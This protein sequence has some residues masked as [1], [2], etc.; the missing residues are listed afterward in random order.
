[1]SGWSARG[2]GT[3]RW[4]TCASSSPRPRKPARPTTAAAS[5]S[6]PTARWRCR[7]GTGSTGARTRRTP[8]TRWAR[9][10]A[11]TATARPARQSPRR[12][13]GRGARDLYA[14]ASQRAG[15]RG[16]SG[17]RRAPRR[18]AWAA[19]RRRVEPAEARRQLRLAA[20]VGRARLQFRARH[21]LRLAAGF[22][23]PLLEWTPS[24]A[25]S[26]LAVY[27]GA[28]FPQWRGAL[29]VPALA[30]KSVRLVHRRDG[31]IVGQEL[32]LGEF[33]ERIRMS[34]SRRTGPSR[35]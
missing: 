19:R 4:R 14:R 24:I 29:L 11:S 15:H 30:E 23:A 34:G 1:M 12:P 9:S 18:R 27:E 16:R 6:C 35:S 2:C 26:G 28:L 22:E 10:C 33:G 7:S 3:G 32:L 20:G 5:P 31:R 13:G 25:P 17:G 21:A 8:P